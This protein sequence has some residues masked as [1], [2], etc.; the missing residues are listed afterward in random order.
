MSKAF[1]VVA[2]RCTHIRVRSLPSRWCRA[3]PLLC[4]HRYS[5]RY[6]FVRMQPTQAKSNFD[7]ISL[8]CLQVFKSVCVSRHVPLA[9][10]PAHVCLLSDQQGRGSTA[11]HY[12][13]ARRTRRVWNRRR[14]GMVA[15]QVRIIAIA[16]WCCADALLT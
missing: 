10:C 9:H 11:Q 12:S 6:Q 13:S 2:A 5:A 4:T 15:C 8:P 3:L 14:F 7:H 16:S 1:E